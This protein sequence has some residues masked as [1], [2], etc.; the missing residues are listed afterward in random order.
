[1]EALLD[2]GNVHDAKQREEI[3]NLLDEAKKRNPIESFNKYRHTT[4]LKLLLL[5]SF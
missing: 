5:F 1:M 4:I 3:R 2:E